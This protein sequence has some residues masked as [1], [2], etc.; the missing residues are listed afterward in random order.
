MDITYQYRIS[1]YFSLYFVLF[2]KTPQSYCA[3]R[4]TP[5]DA[6]NISD[7]SVFCSGNQTLLHLEKLQV[8]CHIR[9]AA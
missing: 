4:F 9:A 8:Y 5:F 2:M 6:I 1:L 3:L 7:R